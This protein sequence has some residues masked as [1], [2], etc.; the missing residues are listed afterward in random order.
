MDAMTGIFRVS[1]KKKE[2]AKAAE[3]DAEMIPMEERKDIMVSKFRGIDPKVEYTFRV[4]TMIN[5]KTIS[6]KMVTLKPDT[7]PKE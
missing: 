3:G 6:R 1:G 2:I 4:C 7:E 5:G